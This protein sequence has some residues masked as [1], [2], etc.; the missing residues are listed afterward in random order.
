[1][2]EKSERIKSESSYY[3]LSHEKINI[4]SEFFS[5]REKIENSLFCWKK[6]PISSLSIIFYIKKTN[7]VF[8]K[9]VFLGFQL[10]IFSV[11]FI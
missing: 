5:I 9:I 10:A 7:F 8:R 11:K 1:M 4:Y 6:S 3:F 2:K